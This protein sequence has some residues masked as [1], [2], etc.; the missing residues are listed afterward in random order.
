MTSLRA[1]LA[2]LL[3]ECLSSWEGASPKDLG[4]GKRTFGAYATD[5][6]S[7]L[8]AERGVKVLDMFPEDDVFQAIHDARNDPKTGK[9]TKAANDELWAAGFRRARCLLTTESGD[10]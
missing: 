5:A 9:P 7:K 2:K 8:L 4:R 3:D 6:L 10:G 1:D